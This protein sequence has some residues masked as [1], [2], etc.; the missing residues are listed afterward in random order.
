[1]AF[2]E[3]ATA[4]AAD[5][6][7]LARKGI[8]A[9]VHREDAHRPFR[10]LLCGDPYLVAQLRALLLRTVEQEDSVPFGASATLETIDPA[11]RPTVLGADARC[12]I[13]LGGPGDAAGADLGLLAQLRLPI[14]ALSVDPSA[15]PNAPS[16]APAAGAVGEY[17][18][19]Q[20]DR[21]SLRPKFFPHLIER[22]KGIEV[23]V[24]RRLP[25][26]RAT[27]AAKLTRDAASSALKVAATSALV[28]HLP[29]LGIVLGAVASAGD[30]VAITGI[31]IVLMMQI[32]ATYGKDPDMQRMWELLPVVGGGLGWRALSREL[33]GYI[34][35]AGVA[36]KSSIAYAGT[37]VVGEGAT[38]YYEHGRHMTAAQASELYEEKKRA[39]MTFA[40]ELFSR[41]R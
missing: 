27:V 7:A 14:F 28:D 20:L 39:A 13:F 22:C 35:V 24:G 6:I 41:V 12:V 38:F 4:G 3:S 19:P 33:S 31:Q 25:A 17:T 40:R 5:L 9:T 18:V 26:L 36:I 30:M 23:A 34:P 11:R 15:S 1:M 10:F 2:S 8:F 29:V 21:E 37:I 32:G 16:D